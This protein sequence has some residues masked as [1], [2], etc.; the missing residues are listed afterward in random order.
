MA[1][2]HQITTWTVWQLAERKIR[3][4]NTN[5]VEED[6]GSSEFCSRLFEREKGGEREG[7]QR[8]QLGN[9]K[10]IKNTKRVKSSCGDYIQKYMNCGVMRREA[11]NNSQEFDSD[12]VGECQEGIDRFL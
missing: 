5:V 4:G 9:I 12:L 10:G 8:G 2:R 7:R 3:Y 6:R 11:W 1:L